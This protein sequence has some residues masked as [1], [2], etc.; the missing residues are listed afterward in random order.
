LKHADVRAAF[1]FGSQVA[2][3]AD[4]DS[5]IDI[6]LFI[7][8]LEGWTLDRRMRLII[9]TQRELGDDLELHLFPASALD[10]ADSASFS[11]YVRT[12]GVA[13]ER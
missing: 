4:P 12:R 2:G 1:L 5:D 11:F 3:T 13:L 8:G 7:D 10:A 6:A 9:E